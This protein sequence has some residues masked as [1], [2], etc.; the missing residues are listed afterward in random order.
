MK[1]MLLVMLASAITFFNV[2]NIAYASDLDIFVM[3]QEIK[4]EDSNKPYIYND[5]TYIPFRKV[6][7]ILNLKLDWE[8]PYVIATGNHAVTGKSIEVKI[9]VGVNSMEVNGQVMKIETPLM[10]NDGNSFIPLRLFG[11]TFGYTVDWLDGQVSITGLPDSFEIEQ[12]VFE[13]VNKIRSEKGL[14]ILVYDEDISKVAKLKADEM[15]SKNYYNHTSPTYGNASDMLD[16][17]GVD[18]WSVAGENIA[19]GQISAN[20]VVNAWLENTQNANNILAGK[21]TKVGIGY[22][23]NSKIWV[24]IFTN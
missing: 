13:I 6:G 18:K 21:F 20:E 24:Q 1:K 23:L 17:F 11:E 9:G 22:N 7:E 4:F 5:R 14:P 15:D 12:E 3:G 2:P 19:K 16:D 8:A 10:L